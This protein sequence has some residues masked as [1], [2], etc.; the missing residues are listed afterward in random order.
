MA[1]QAFYVMVERKYGDQE[2]S[3]YPLWEAESRAEA[4]DAHDSMPAMYGEV[5]R[6]IVAGPASGDCREHRP[7]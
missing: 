5:S 6:T 4:Q 3:W 1:K 7:C 2:S